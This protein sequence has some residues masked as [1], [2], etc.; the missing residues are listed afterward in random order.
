[1][2][3]EPVLFVLSAAVAT[4]AAAESASSKASLHF[5]QLAPGIAVLF[6]DR[7][8]NVGLSYGQDGNLLI[9]DQ[10]A[11]L[12]PKIVDA[13]RSLN[14][15]PIRIVIN[16]HWHADHTGG[17][18]LLAKDGAVIIAQDAARQ[19]MSV[20]QVIKT[21]SLK[22]PALP[23]DA[24]PVITFADGLK[25]HFNGDDIQ[26]IHIPRAHTD[27]DALVYFSKAKV[28]L[29]GDIF[30]RS[31]MPIIDIDSDGSIDGMI[32]VAK[33]ALAMVPE[34]AKIVPGHGP[35]STKEDLRRHLVLL[36]DVRGKVAAARAGGR[37]LAEI[38]AMKIAAPYEV[39]GSFLSADKFVELVYKS[40]ESSAP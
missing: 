34:D 10:T 24:W 4:A 6:G 31:D 27:G 20:E 5:E 9:D 22:F 26:V 13:A 38:Q 3:I 33:T 39:K 35:I 2:R 15:A 30:V 16:T 29:T 7:V 17:N 25:L 8:G 36:E 32:A 19:R 23:Q 11:Q 21:F 28:L 18:E 12:V 1:M 37:S 40:L 14:P